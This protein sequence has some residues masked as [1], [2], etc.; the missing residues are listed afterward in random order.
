[1]EGWSLGTGKKV[2]SRQLTNS[3]SDQADSVRWIMDA[4]TGRLYVSIRSYTAAIDVET[5]SV[6]WEVGFGVSDY[7]GLY[8]LGPFVAAGNIILSA[9][10][11]EIVA[12]NG[13]GGVRVDF[14]RLVLFGNRLWA[15]DSDGRWHVLD[16]SNTHAPWSEPADQETPEEGHGDAGTRR[17]GEGGGELLQS[18]GNALPGAPVTSR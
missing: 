18:P 17:R 16:F 9:A 10:E 14:S 8:V 1:V 5:G 15:Q 13:W 4:A 2:Y 12:P 11:G 7:A 3:R 6:M